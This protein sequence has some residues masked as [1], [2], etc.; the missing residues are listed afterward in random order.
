MPKQIEL[1]FLELDNI[2]FWSYRNGKKIGELKFTDEG[3][4]FRGKADECTKIFFDE[5]VKRMADE[6]IKKKLGKS[7][8]KKQRR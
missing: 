6:Y 4:K 7:I 2:T 8:I 1:K 5:C 3:L